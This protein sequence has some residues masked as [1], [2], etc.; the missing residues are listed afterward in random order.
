M[1]KDQSLQKDLVTNSKLTEI[2]TLRTLPKKEDIV[3]NDALIKGL[4][5]DE[6]IYDLV[7]TVLIELAEETASLKFERIKLEERDQSTGTISVRR[8]Q[9]LKMVMDALV[10]R[11]NIAL[12]DFINL[13]SPQWQIIFSHLMLKIRQTFLDLNYNTEQIELFFQSLQKNLEGFEEEA[14]QRLKES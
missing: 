5:G 11:R 13:K 9:V 7:N 6:N 14:E 1:T 3:R 2:K 4:L 12:N 10:Q 8:A